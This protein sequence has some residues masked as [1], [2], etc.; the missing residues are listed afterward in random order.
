[1][2]PA[3][4]RVFTI[5]LDNPG[6]AADCEPGIL[7]RQS[8]WAGKI[9]QLLRKGELE[10]PDALLELEG[11]VDLVMN[12]GTPSYQGY[13]SDFE[14]ASRLL[15]DEGMILFHYFG[16]SEEAREHPAV[17][18]LNELASEGEWVLR[19]ILGTDLVIGRRY[20][21]DADPG[22][23][24]DFAQGTGVAAQGIMRIRDTVM[25]PA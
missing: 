8:G 7:F 19:H 12:H 21:P 4:G 22:E 10:I 6:L 15:S 24:I 20:W 25:A 3:T 17:A 18:V 1:M 2:G 14:A 16:H 11:K 23:I 13:R 9:T 5:D